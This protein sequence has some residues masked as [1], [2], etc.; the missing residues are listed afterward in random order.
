MI[1]GFD[2]IAISY[3]QKGKGRERHSLYWRRRLRRSRRLSRG[4]EAESEPSFAVPCVPEG[5]PW[6]P[7]GVPAE[8]FDVFSMWKPMQAPS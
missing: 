3:L 2:F 6:F 7:E 5:A 8:V 1:Y 4:L